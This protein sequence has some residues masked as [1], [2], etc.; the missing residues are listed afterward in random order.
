MSAVILCS[1]VCFRDAIDKPGMCQ[2]YEVRHKQILQFGRERANMGM[3]RGGGGGGVFVF[4]VCLVVWYFVV[5][6]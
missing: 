3:P 5:V 6:V 1:T 4:F 2:R